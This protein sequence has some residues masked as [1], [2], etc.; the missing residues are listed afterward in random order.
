MADKL[1]EKRFCVDSAVRG[2]HIYKKF[3]VS[4]SKMNLRAT[5]LLI[6]ISGLHIDSLVCFVRLEIG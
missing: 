2:L 5:R 4:H 1:T 3:L 6:L